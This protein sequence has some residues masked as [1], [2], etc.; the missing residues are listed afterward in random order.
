M[1]SA[2]IITHFAAQGIAISFVG[3]R[4]NARIKHGKI[5]DDQKN[6]I[7]TYKPI[8]LAYFQGRLDAH[9]DG[10]PL[11]KSQPPVVSVNTYSKTN[12]FKEYELPDGTT[13]Q[14]SR[15]E[16][17]DVV[18]LFRIRLSQSEKPMGRRAG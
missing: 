14:L 9:N 11:P 6:L 3:D 8:L 7:V 4:I 18:D 15:E 5:T 10:S 12:C 2:E 17:D 16:F 13:L 1:N